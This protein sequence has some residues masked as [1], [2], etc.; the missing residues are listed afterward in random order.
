[1]V[2]VV[3]FFGLNRCVNLADSPING[4]LSKSCICGAFSNPDNQTPNQKKSKNLRVVRVWRVWWACGTCGASVV[5]VVGV[6]GACG[7]CGANAF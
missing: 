6:C 5:R 3:N 4:T 1:V 2:R 7:V